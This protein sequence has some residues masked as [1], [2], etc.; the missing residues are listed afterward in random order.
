MSNNL[1]WMKLHVADYLTDTGHLSTLEHGAYLLL[2]MHAWT[3][4]GMLP[5][6]TS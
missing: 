3:R 4:G 2:L 5:A 1:P 6:P